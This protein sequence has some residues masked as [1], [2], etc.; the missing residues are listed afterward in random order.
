MSFAMPP[1]MTLKKATMV[2]NLAADTT[3]PA[4]P[5]AEEVPAELPRKRAR[6]NGQFCGDD[7]AT[8]EKNEAWME[9]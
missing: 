8:D 1:G 7:L 6:V 2:M 9:T 3:E 4:P 5:A